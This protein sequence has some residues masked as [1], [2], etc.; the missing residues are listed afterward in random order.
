MCLICLEVMSKRMKPYEARLA[1]VELKHI[2]PEDHAKQ[3]EA[4]INLAELS[5]VL[6]GKL[7]QEDLRDKPTL[8]EEIL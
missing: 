4:T 1:K 8:E 2:I 6:E 5:D 3:L 7:D